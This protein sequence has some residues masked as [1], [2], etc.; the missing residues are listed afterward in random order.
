MT[1]VSVGGECLFEC[2]VGPEFDSKSPAFVRSR[3]S[4]AAGSDGALAQKNGNEPPSLETGI[5]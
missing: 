3:A 2:V 4:Q 1:G 5:V